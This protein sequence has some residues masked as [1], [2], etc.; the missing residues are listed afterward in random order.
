MKICGKNI[1]VETYKYCALIQFNMFI[2]SYPYPINHI[3]KDTQ[4]KGGKYFYTWSSRWAPTRPTNT[5]SCTCTSRR[6]VTGTCSQRCC[7]CWTGR[8][9]SWRSSIKIFTS[10]VLCIFGYVIN[11]IRIW[12]YENIK[13]DRGTIFVRFHPDILPTY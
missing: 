1:R 9:P 13:L 6:S 7:V 5:A 2:S 11:W 10:F 3:T 12:R 8:C 4:N